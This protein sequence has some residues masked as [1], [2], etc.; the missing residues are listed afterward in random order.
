VAGPNLTR[1]VGLGA[2]GG[3]LTG[4]IFMFIKGMTWTPDCEGVTPD[5]CA[6]LSDLIEQ[7]R[8]LHLLSAA[9]LCS[10]SA[11]ILLLVLKRKTT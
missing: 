5:E 9:G 2:G 10:L 1:A 11:G 4:A 6:L 8:G 3:A 7:T